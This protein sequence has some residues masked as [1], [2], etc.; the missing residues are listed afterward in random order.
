[1][2][3]RLFI[4]GSMLRSREAAF[5]AAIAKSLEEHVW[6]LLISNQIRPVIYE[7]FPASQA[8]QAH[9]LMEEGSHKGKI[10]LSF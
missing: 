6:P 8:A 9:E 5:K 2:R 10:V 7:V 1:M 3:K 4:T